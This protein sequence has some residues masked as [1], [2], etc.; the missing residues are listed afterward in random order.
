MIFVSPAEPSAIRTHFEV[1]S[2]CEQHGA[3]FMFSS[4]HGMIGVQRKEVRDLVA[5]IRDDRIAREIGQSR[6]L[7]QLVL[8]VEGD[9][10]WKR[11]NESGRVDGFT[12]QQFDGLMLSF[13]S[14]GW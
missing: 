10:K 4:P 11:N 1:S 3:D 7:A 12:R 9:W 14:H 8:I 2:V 5:S 13:Q 6:Q